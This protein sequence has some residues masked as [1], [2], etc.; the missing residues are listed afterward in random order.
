MGVLVSQEYD[1]RPR[2]D[3]SLNVPNFEC[4]TVEIKTHSNSILV[5]SLYRPPNSK[6]KD[7]LRNYRRLLDKFTVNQRERL[8]VGLDHNLDLMKHESHAPTKEF[9]DLNLDLNLIP[10]ITK[11]TRISKS[12]ATL[13]DN[14]IVGKQFHNF[15][16]NI[17][18]S[19]ISDHLPV[20]LNSHQPNLYKKQA[21]TMTT[22]VINDEACHKIIESLQNWD[23]NHCLK[24]KTTNEAF[25]CFHQKTQ[26]VLDNICPLKEI[27]IRPSKISER[28][29]DDTWT[30]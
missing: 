23:W 18:I 30:T 19:D 2:P 5:C 6:V 11:P 12:S 25:A 21:L 9:I 27:K 13:L 28:P 3:L 8:I 26:E 17:A 29:L 4:L 14:L 24:D 20:V 10:T 16:A 15:V 1:C 22:R 7:F